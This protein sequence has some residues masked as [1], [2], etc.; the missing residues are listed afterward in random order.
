[1]NSCGD[2]ASADM[3]AAH[4]KITRMSRSIDQSAVIQQQTPLQKGSL[5]FQFEYSHLAHLRGIQE[6]RA[7]PRR[8]IEADRLSEVRDLRAIHCS[9]RKQTTVPMSSRVPIPRNSDVL[10]PKI[11]QGFC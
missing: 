1:M 3:R 7:N 9:K 8:R 11:F 10:A 5:T 6:T 2:A 4:G